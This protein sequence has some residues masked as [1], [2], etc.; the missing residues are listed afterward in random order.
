MYDLIL[1]F[2]CLPLDGAHDVAPPTY[3][4][5]VNISDKKQLVYDEA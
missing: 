5:V 2:N 3:D 1:M 4:Q